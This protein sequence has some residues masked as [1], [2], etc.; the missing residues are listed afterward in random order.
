MSPDRLATFERQ[1]REHLVEFGRSIT[2]MRG[3][4]PLREAALGAGISHTTLYRIELGLSMPNMKVFAGISYSL[5]LLPEEEINTMGLAL[6]ERAED[7]L[8][9]RLMRNARNPAEE[10]SG[11]FGERLRKYREALGVSLRALALRSGIGP[12]NISKYEHDDVIPLVA[13]F[14]SHVLALRISPD[15]TQALI[16]PLKPETTVYASQ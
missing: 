7:N 11:T 9:D 16:S 6:P 14:A 12:R 15:Q 3:R 4:T 10:V 8:W 5:G 2:K 13:T 1:P